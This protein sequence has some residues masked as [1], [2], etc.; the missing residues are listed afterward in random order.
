MTDR[1]PVSLAQSLWAAADVSVVIA[2]PVAVLHAS[3]GLLRLTGSDRERIVGRPLASLVAQDE[4]TAVEQAL[5]EAYAGASEAR[6]PEV[7]LRA[8]GHEP[9]QGSVICRGIDVEGVRLVVVTFAPAGD[10]NRLADV[11]AASEQR[12][13]DLFEDDIDGRFVAAPDWRIIDCNR[14]LARALGYDDCAPLMGRSLLDL[15]PDGPILQKLMA[16]TRAEGRAGPFELQMERSD[17]QQIDVSCIVT[18]SFNASGTLVSLRG[19]VAEVTERK[20][21]ETR[22]Q[23][24]ERMEVIGRLAGGLAH[25]FNNLLT[26]IRGNTERLL[27]VPPPGAEAMTSA[28]QAI[29]QAAERAATMT[30]QLLAYGRRQVFDVRPVSLE[31]LITDLLPTLGEILGDHIRVDTELKH[32]LPSISADPRQIEQVLSNLAMNAREAMR[33]GGVLT[34]TLDAMEVPDQARRQHVWLRPGSYVRL[35]VR[36]NGHG[37]DPVTRAYAFQ[38]FYT[39]KRMG[40]GHG[41]GLATV[42]GIVKQSRGFVWVES[43]EHAGAAFTLLFPALSSG[44]RSDAVESRSGANETILVVEE[45]EAA[46]A[47][48]VGA[49]RRRGYRVLDAASPDAALALFASQA[50]RVHLVLAGSRAVVQGVPFVSRL[51]GIDPLLQSLA[52]LEPEAPSGSGPRVLPTTPSIQKPFTLQ[53]LAEKVR[54]VLDSGTGRK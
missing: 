2:S 18:A 30:Q 33:S 15:T 16:I 19:Q 14:V 44:G 34:V 42:Y 28:V 9:I 45:D 10:L 8:N 43:E 46:R 3:P 1:L 26:V 53:A 20:R 48:V 7:T 35:V 4:R 50:S 36:D 41:L 38:P 31:H 29:D 49:L 37:M 32:G 5:Q 21:L 6:V 25:D 54:E 12:Y 24:A 11:L 13:R 17:G 23:G 47:F 39:T 51:Q 27:E 40:N 52:M 22:L